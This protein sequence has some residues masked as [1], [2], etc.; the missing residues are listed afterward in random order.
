[1]NDV[2]NGVA[3]S[4]SLAQQ[5]GIKEIC[6]SWRKL[7]PKTRTWLTNSGLH[8]DRGVP[9]QV[10]SSDSEVEDLEFNLGL[11]NR[12]VAAKLPNRAEKGALIP[13]EASASE[14]QSA[15]SALIISRVAKP[16]LS[17][18]CSTCAAAL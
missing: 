16:C 18:A 11:I 2:A 14:V 17:P 10:E 9:V 5:E 12:Y 6:R 4:Y 1:M 8:N 7:H 13:S 15:P 3:D